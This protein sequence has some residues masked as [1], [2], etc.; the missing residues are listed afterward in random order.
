[1]EHI[2]LQQAHQ[3]LLAPYTDY[4]EY[5]ATLTIKQYATIHTE[6]LPS[7]GQGFVLTDDILKSTIRYFTA[8]LTRFLYGNDAKKLHKQ[9]YAQPLL[10]FVVEGVNSHKR[11]HLH[12]ALGNVPDHK[13][14]D[15][16][17]IIKQAW[18]KCDF[19]NQQVKVKPIYNAV[20][21]TDYITKEIEFEN[22]DALYIV[23][24]V[25]PQVC[26]A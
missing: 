1:M 21:W 14:A 13:K 9:H 24:S 16:E 6:Y 20:G 26:R 15:I 23:D 7:L 3:S 5:A 4:F 22:N 2:K 8:H 17:S 10:F 18:A 19:A 12:I 11:E 25:I